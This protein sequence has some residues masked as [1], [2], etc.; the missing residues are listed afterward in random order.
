MILIGW[1][2]VE[3]LVWQNRY[4]LLLLVVKSL[5][6]GA[7]V[8]M[9]LRVDAWTE[10]LFLVMIDDLDCCI[11][12]RTMIYMDDLT[13]ISRGASFIS[14]SDQIERAINV[15]CGSKQIDRCLMRLKR[16]SQDILRK[17]MINRTRSSFWF[18]NSAS[19][20]WTGVSILRQLKKYLVPAI[21]LLKRLKECVKYAYC[22]LLSFT[23]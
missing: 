21:F 18:S 5:V 2:L 3:F 7:S 22:T 9:C 4:S 15:S 19:I 12:G 1:Q 11:S 20:K 16:S 13:I 10:L 8:Q 17:M 23:V 14:A 6:L